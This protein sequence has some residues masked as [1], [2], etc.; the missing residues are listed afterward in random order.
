MR[1]LACGLLSI[2]KFSKIFVK[3]SANKL[4]FRFMPD[5]W[6]LKRLI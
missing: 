1:R 5:F 2:P 3:P 4:R 6:H